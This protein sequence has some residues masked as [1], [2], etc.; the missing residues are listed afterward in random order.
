MKGMNRRDFLKTVAVGGTA[1]GMGSMFF[2]I[3]VEDDGCV[4][5]G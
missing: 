5:L 1:V 3:G 4:G 2:D